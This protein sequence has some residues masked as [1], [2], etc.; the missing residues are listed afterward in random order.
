MH[1]LFKEFQKLREICSN[2]VLLIGNIRIFHEISVNRFLIDKI[3]EI[4]GRIKKTFHNQTQSPD[5][6]LL[7]WS[8]SLNHNN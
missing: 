3:S 5:S 6:F 4:L 1:K 2:L 7:N 8:T